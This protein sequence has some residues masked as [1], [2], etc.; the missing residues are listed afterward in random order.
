MHRAKVYAFTLFQVAPMS[1]VGTLW[2]AVAGDM[3]TTF[4]VTLNWLQPLPA[5]EKDWRAVRRKR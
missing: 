4:V 2:M 3:G 5:K 1:G